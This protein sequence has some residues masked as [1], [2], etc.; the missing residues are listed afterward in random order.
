MFKSIEGL[1]FPPKTDKWESTPEL[2]AWWNKQFEQTQKDDISSKIHVIVDQPSFNGE[3]ILSSGK[4]FKKFI[5]R[6]QT[7]D[8]Y[9]GQDN[10]KNLI[11][12]NIRKIKELKPVNFLLGGGRGHGKTSLSH[13]IKNMLNGKLIERIGKQIITNDDIINIVNEINQSKEE[14][15]ILFIDEIHSLDS[16]LCE[17]FYPIIEDFK[18]AGKNIKPFVLIGATT[19]KNILLKKNAPFVDRFQ[20]Q[21][22]LEKY[23]TQNIVDILTQYKNQLYNKYNVHPDA[24][25]KLALNCKRTPRIAISLL[26]DAI[27][28]SNIDN[29]LKCHRIV[30]N[31]LNEND[32]NI[33]RI[34]IQNQKPLGSKALAQMI[35]ISERDYLEC[36]EAFLV[37][38]EFILRTGRGRMIGEKGKEI[39][40][41]IIKG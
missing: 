31:G 40:N 26:E 5:Y 16:S 15:I 7:L 17:I 20:V 35:G 13:I 1:M 36:C 11:S 34:L 21:V 2:T 8:E 19:E 27:I 32:V 3:N 30:H 39:Y 9:I 14:H 22:D 41:I 18:I 28:E 38:E 33:L 4:E 24:I 25:L 6:P 37:E 29:V 10:A 12:L 23:T